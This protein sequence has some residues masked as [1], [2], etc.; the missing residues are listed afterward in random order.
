[1]DKAFTLESG[2][3]NL[4]AMNAAQS[5]QAAMARL[6]V[7]EMGLRQ[8][9]VLDF[10][11]GTGTYSRAVDRMTGWDIFAMEPHRELH[12]AF[13][14]GIKVVSSLEEVAPISLDGA[15]SLNV[16]EHIED[17]VAALRDLAACCKPGAPIFVLVPAHM[18]LWSPMD[19]L[20]GHV[21]RYS[22]DSLAELGHSAGLKVV[23]Q[24][25]FDSTGYFATK[26]YRLATRAGL[27]RGPAGAISKWQVGAF[28]K[29]FD[30]AEPVLHWVAPGKNCWVRLAHE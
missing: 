28:D 22:R 7:R 25:W 11:A 4:E 29:V 23:R 10:G 13:G 3:A 1:M 21:R 8:G 20:V 30:L 6:V 14:R 24:G 15:F 12:P 18:S 17:D 9:M 5:Y 26:V 2:S 16:F 19:D 27:L